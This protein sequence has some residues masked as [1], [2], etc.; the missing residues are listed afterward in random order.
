MPEE[1]RKVSLEQ[2]LRLSDGHFY[3]SF[4]R[5][6]SFKP[7]QVI[8]ITNDP[9]LEPRLYSLASS[10]T[11]P[12][13]S[14]LYSVKEG[15]ELT[16]ALA[17]MKAGDKIWVTS[18]RGNFL[19]RDLPAWWI[20]SGTGIAPFLSWL[21]S[22]LNGPE[23][24]IFG[25]RDMDSLH[26][27]AELK[28]MISDR[29]IPCCSRVDV[30]DTFHGRVSDY[31]RKMDDLPPRQVYFLCGVAEMVIDVREILINKGIDMRQ[32]HAEIYF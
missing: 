18:P 16:P 19:H 21:R 25:A 3:L 28:E 17:E 7:G 30:P 26:F 22:G 32:I 27:H 31:L 11:A 24:L 29:Y 6:F 23:R 15:G 10:D 5:D 9:R 4:F 12:F 13:A 20:A 14:V 8:G 1:L 2:N